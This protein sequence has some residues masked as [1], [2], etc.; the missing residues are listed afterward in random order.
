MYNTSKFKPV[1]K[2]LMSQS[3]TEPSSK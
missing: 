3:D 2:L 1:L